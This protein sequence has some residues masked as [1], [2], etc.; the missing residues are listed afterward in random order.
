LISAAKCAKSSV[1]P[2]DSA[3]V[4]FFREGC[5]LDFGLHPCSSSLR[6]SYLLHPAIAGLVAAPSILVWE[7][8]PFAASFLVLRVLAIFGFAV[9]SHGLSAQCVP[10][11]GA[12]IA[13]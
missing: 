9:L 8:I 7:A 10:S 1:L 5:T 6:S 11:A 2:T 4:R 13:Y 3:T 12:G